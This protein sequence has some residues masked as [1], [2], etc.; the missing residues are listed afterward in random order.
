MKS[1][2][3]ATAEY[4]Q[5]TS[6]KYRGDGG[7]G[8]LHHNYNIYHDVRSKADVCKVASDDLSFF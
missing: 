3:L 1:S 2:C 7:L 8:P 4:S 6:V 5:T